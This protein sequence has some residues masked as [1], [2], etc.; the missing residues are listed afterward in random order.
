MHLMHTQVQNLAGRKSFKVYHIRRK[1]PSPYY[2]PFLPYI[3]I[4]IKN[5]ESKF[6]KK[7][8]GLYFRLLKF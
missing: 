2:S 8:K 1:G 3:L 5:S 6:V 4:P 7:F